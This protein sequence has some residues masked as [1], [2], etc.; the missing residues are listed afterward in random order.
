[1]SMLSTLS[2]YAAP[3]LVVVA[4]LAMLLP[5]WPDTMRHFRT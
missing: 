3:G 2:E 1:M 5:H 4:G